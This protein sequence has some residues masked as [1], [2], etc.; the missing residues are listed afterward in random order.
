MKA[1]SED[2]EKLLEQ[3][4]AEE[5]VF[6][7]DDHGE[8]EAD[9][10]LPPGDEP[11]IVEGED[12][13]H[14]QASPPVAKRYR[15]KGPPEPQDEIFDELYVS[16]V[17]GEG[18]APFTNYM[19][20]LPKTPRAKEKALEKEIPWS[21]I[22]EEQREG[23]RSAERTQYDEHLQHG[24]LEPLT[25][26]A[27]REVQRTK[28]ERVL[29]SRFAYRDKYWSKRKEQPEIGW[30]HK[31]RLVIAG[32][33]DPDL[34]CGLST[35]APTVSR[36][37]ILL[38]LQILASN[39][40]R[41]WTGHAG[42]V[43]AAFLCGEELT[44]ELYLRQP[45]SGLGDLHPE[46]LLRIRK[47]IFGLVD[48][49][50]AWW[51]KF[52]KS[53]TSTRIHGQG[54]RSWT[55]SN[56]SLDH[57]IFVVQ[58]EIQDENGS[59]SLRT[60]EAYIGVHVDDVLQI[61][62]DEL[63]R[64]I[65]EKLSEQFPI[66]EWE[67][68]SFDY[69]GSYVDIKEN[70]IIVS[71]ASY[72]ATR[73]F[74]VEIQKGQDDEEI[75]NEVQKHDNMSLIGALSWLASQSR[76][77]LQ[78]GV[79]MCQQRQRDPTIADIKFTNLLA[80][81][82]YEHQKEGIRIYPIDLERA[83]LL[84]Y[85]DAGWANVPQNQED[86]YYSLTPEE[87]DAGRITTGPQSRCGARAKRANSS[88]C[89]QLGGLFLLS[90]KNILHGKKENVSVMDWRSGACDRVCR[91]TFAAETMACATAIETGIFISRFLETLLS[92]KL[93]RSTSRL[94]L[95]FLSDCRS[96]YDHLIRD[97]VPRVPSCKRLA[98]DL[99]AIR[100]DLSEVGKIAW[101]PTGAQMSDHLTKPLKAGEWWQKLSS[102]FQL[103]FKE[104][105]V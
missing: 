101:V 9:P 79:S 5:E 27:S 99:A 29:G 53:L 25:V 28:P 12:E 61:G 21:I 69:V 75:A 80:Q 76:P 13:D 49:P 78:V 73:L 91:S 36:Q 57:C 60:P 1:T 64:L 48:S 20:K 2:L 95:R 67:S 43:T 3:P 30:K 4:F 18:P 62:D 98:I 47:P 11:M 7:G 19:M 37:G 90:D 23:F 59:K 32:H 50:A 74:E 46:Q 105:I 89:S 10:E 92:G 8:A 16:T 103:T 42:D 82:A 85:H 104:D 41:G 66:R 70:M 58:E 38:L 63:C 24:A 68:G 100:D 6:A 94:Q 34:L 22:P 93:A 83:V 17:G 81:R 40:H 26:E 44:R 77:D 102:G 51:G 15:T 88:V 84:C 31:A 65:K 14:M 35:H 86:P 54:G 97:G 71:Q 45:R 39:L 55:I 96:L 33:R 52:R 56:C 72:T 87:N